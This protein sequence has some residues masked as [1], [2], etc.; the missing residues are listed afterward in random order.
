LPQEDE[1]QE[2]IE[3]KTLALPSS[4]GE[5]TDVTQDKEA[6]RAYLAKQAEGEVMDLMDICWMHK[7]LFK[8]VKPGSVKGHYHRID[9]DTQKGLKARIYPLRNESQREAARKEIENLLKGGMI[10]PVAASSY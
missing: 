3:W 9:L 1:E 2:E 6:M 5:V 10:Q 4:K 7:E 8:T